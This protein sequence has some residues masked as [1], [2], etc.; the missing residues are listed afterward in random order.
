[1]MYDIWNNQIHPEYNILVLKLDVD[2][3]CLS[4][5]DSLP[6][7]ASDPLHILANWPLSSIHRVF[8]A[9]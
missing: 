6:Y 8:C 5:I 7:L 2:S 1:M 4:K 9:E 3:F